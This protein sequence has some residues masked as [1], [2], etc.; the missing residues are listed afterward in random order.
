M[1][2]PESAL[3]PSL[4]WGKGGHP[5]PPWQR[6]V[7]LK[8]MEAEVTRRKLASLDILR[9]LWIS[10]SHILVPEVTLEMYARLG[11]WSS[12]KTQERSCY[13]I[14]FLRGEE[15]EGKKEMSTWLLLFVPLYPHMSEQDPRAWRTQL[16]TAGADREFPLWS[17]EVL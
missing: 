2:A 8:S 9:G 5:L 12:Q 4:A 13:P 6:D 17:G 10:I 11:Q 15:M 7:V 16:E 14:G 1:E 3:R